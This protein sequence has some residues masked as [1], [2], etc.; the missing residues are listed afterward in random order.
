M[1]SYRLSA[2]LTLALVMLL[3]SCDSTDPGADPPDDAFDRSEMLSHLGH[4]V[5]LPAYASLQISVANLASATD[6][7][8][9][10]P[11]AGTL[12]AL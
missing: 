5:I 11:S 3:A 4:E 1:H 8:A 12:T 6:D 7:F 10:D 9:A 2:L